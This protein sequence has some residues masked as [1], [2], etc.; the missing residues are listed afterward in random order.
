MKT[1]PIFRITSTIAVLMVAAGL[2]PADSYSEGKVKS[3]PPPVATARAE[4]A[5]E[6][7]AALDEL[8]R[9]KRESDTATVARLHDRL[10][11]ADMPTLASSMQDGPEI[12]IRTDRHRD[13]LKW[14]G[15]TLVSLPQWSSG[16][17]AM[18]C[19][20]DGT[21]YVIA[22]DMVN[23]TY[24]DLYT[25]ADGGATWNYEYSL[26]DANNAMY[27][28]SIAIG[29]GVSNRLLIAYESDRNTADAKVVVYWSDLD[30]DDSGSVTLDTFANNVV[31]HPKICVDSPEYSVWYAYLT[32]VRAP[33]GV[34]DHD[35][36]Y[37]R[38][39][40][41]GVSW[42]TPTMFSNSVHYGNDHDLD[43]GAAGVFAA[44]TMI[45]TPTHIRVQRST[46]FGNTWSIY[47][48][49]TT[50]VDVFEPS[51][52]VS[53]TGDTAVVAFAA[54][55]GGGDSD[56]EAWVTDDGG[57]SWSYA[58][59]PYDAQPEA[60]SNLAYDPVTDTFHATFNRANGVVITQAEPTALA[61]WSPLLRVNEQQSAT[62]F[63]ENAIAA[64]PT[65]THGVGIAWMDLRVPG[66]FGVYFDAS[67]V[68]NP[69]AVEYLMICPDALIDPAAALAHYRE[70]RG[71]GVHLVTMSQIGPAPLSEA[72]IDL[73]VKD[74]ASGAPQLRFLALIGDV[75]LLPSFYVFDGSEEWYSD[76]RYAD[77]DGDFA[78]DYLPDIAVGR[79][80]VQT[81][82][83]LW[84]YV[85]KVKTF[86]QTFELRNKVLFFGDLAEMSYVT[87]RD[88]LAISDTG[89]DVSTF[90]D[91]SE[92]Q[93]LAAL[94]DPEL[95]MVLYYGHGSF[96]NNWPLHL[97]NLDDWTNEARPVLY[98]SGGCDFND[99]TLL[100]PPLGH[101]LL[102]SPGCA[103]AATGATV[104]GGYG[105]DYQYIN[106]LLSDAWLYTT[107]GELHRHALREHHDI[108]SSQGQAVN[109]GSWVHYFTERMMCHGDPAL[110]IDGDVTA[111]PEA[112]PS[113]PR[114]AG[115]YP[116]PFNPGT[117]IR[118]ELPE[119]TAVTLAVYDLQGR[120]VRKLLNGASRDAGPHEVVWDGRD[121]RGAAAAS[122][123][124]LYRLITERGEEAGKMALTK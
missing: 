32:Y 101:E 30:T 74:Y 87:N 64:D 72:D 119:R 31:G 81:A 115:N 95:V 38:T 73:F 102:F 44:M 90:Y 28:P 105:Y 57:D 33:S 117:T 40:D 88:S 21:F 15:D 42:T 59:L 107:M 17:H 34:F 116:N 112:P 83:E 122:G 62:I 114:L 103:T 97:G 124:Y 55:Y 37:S 69:R 36:M 35:L 12:V 120:M 68:V 77:T 2:A 19:R 18:T 121:A 94:N 98:F 89:R 29:E 111:V 46:D 100:N 25:S 5:P 93:L 75:D 123:V 99:N 91:P 43:F 85:A 110:R 80:P 79:I 108:A 92:A 8:R 7:A 56:I 84:D 96:A 113:R 10:G 24:L 106:A 49:G 11:W 70:L 23:S 63:V 14:G 50:P 20:S 109:Q 52:A 9:A 51:V 13:P 47:D 45:A 60:S 61:A 67:D 22:V 41:Y 78:T 66:Q 27:M 104:S 6:R 65:G 76:L 16:F 86:E 71:Y 26:S 53:N 39:L 48:L 54:D 58:I 4:V 3:P 82:D 118:F 1:R